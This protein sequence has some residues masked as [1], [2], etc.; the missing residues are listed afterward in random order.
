VSFTA[1][2]DPGGVIDHVTIAAFVLAAPTAVASEAAV[3]GLRMRCD[4][5]FFG[6]SPGI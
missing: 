3:F 4:F 2:I 6:S 1:C 5:M